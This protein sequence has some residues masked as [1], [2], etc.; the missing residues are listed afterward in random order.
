MIRPRLSAM[1][2][3]LQQKWDELLPGKAYILGTYNTKMGG[4]PYGRG[5]AYSYKLNSRAPNSQ[6]YWTVRWQWVTP[7]LAGVTFDHPWSTYT[8]VHIAPDAQVGIGRIE[9]VYTRQTDGFEVHSEPMFINI[10]QPAVETP[11]DV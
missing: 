6:D 2:R 11:A 10:F 1:A 3:W 5:K 8:V 9:V 7:P 4:L